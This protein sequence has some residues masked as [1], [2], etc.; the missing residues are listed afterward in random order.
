MPGCNVDLSLEIPGCGFTENC[1]L[2]KGK[3]F[4]ALYHLLNGLR[5]VVEARG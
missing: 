5:G 1:V 2:P 3:V 4:S